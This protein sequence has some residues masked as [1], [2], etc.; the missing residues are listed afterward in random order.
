[1]DGPDDAERHQIS[2][3][4]W[5]I[6]QN[7]G[8]GNRGWDRMVATLDVVPTTA[9]AWKPNGAKAKKRVPGTPNGYTLLRMLRLAGV[10]D[11]DFQI[12][13]HLRAA[14]QAAESGVA[15]AART[16]QRAQDDRGRAA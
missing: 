7:F 13:N 8:E 1:M 3:L 4:I 9:S 16:A 14:V 10:L 2:R 6:S 11:E 5:Y 12:P 15:P